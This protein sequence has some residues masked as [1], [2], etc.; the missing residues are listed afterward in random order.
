MFP[1]PKKSYMKSG[2]SCKVTFY[3][4]ADVNASTVAVCGEF[5]E[6]NPEALPMK[7]RKDGVHYASA[8]LDSGRAYRYRFLLDGA[9]WENDWEA[10]S[11]AA[12]EHGTD[13][14]VVTV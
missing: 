11:Y 2:R 14:S 4:P 3:L 13:D 9:R 1:M 12:N 6:W 10:E 8:Y 7:I 5:N